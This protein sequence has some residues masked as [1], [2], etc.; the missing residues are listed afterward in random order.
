MLASVGEQPGGPP[1]IARVRLI[2]MLPGAHVGDGVHPVPDMTLRA[3]LVLALPA[4]LPLR[5]GDFNDDTVEDARRP[6]KEAAVDPCVVALD[7]S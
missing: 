7:F 2:D 4:R 1:E 5:E 3:Q 6:D